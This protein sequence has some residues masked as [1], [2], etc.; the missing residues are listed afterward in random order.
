M[1]WQFFAF[2][3]LISALHLN[4]RMSQ[5][6]LPADYARN[7]RPLLA[8]VQ[9]LFPLQLHVRCQVANSI[10]STW[11]K[12]Q[13]LGQRSLS[14]SEANLSQVREGHSHLIISFH[15]QDHKTSLSFAELWICHIPISQQEQ[16]YLYETLLRYHRE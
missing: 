15:Y 16:C 13:V 9:S 1:L 3:R 10:E 7:H 5:D 4:Q 14:Y 8:L 11:Q 6:R 2:V 12:A